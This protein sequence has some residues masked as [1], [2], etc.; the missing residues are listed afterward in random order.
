MTKRAL[1][2]SLY[3]PRATH[4]IAKLRGSQN[5]PSAAHERL[6]QDLEALEKFSGQVPSS[7]RSIRAKCR[8]EM[9]SS[10]D[11]AI[12]RKRNRSPIIKDV[13]EEMVQRHEEYQEVFALESIP[14]SDIS[15]ELA[16]V[17][18]IDELARLYEKVGMSPE[19]MQEKLFDPDKS[20]EYT[21]GIFHLLNDELAEMIDS[22][23]YIFL[24]VS[25]EDENGD[26]R[27][28][29]CLSVRTDNKEYKQ[30]AFNLSEFSERVQ[31]KFKEAVDNNR[32]AAALDIVVDPEFQGR[33]VSLAVEYCM[34]KILAR[35]GFDFAMFEIYKIVGAQNEDG[36]IFE[37][38]LP[39]GPSLRIHSMIGAK[40]VGTVER[41][42]QEVGDWQVAVDSMLYCI[43]L[44]GIDIIRRRVDQFE[45]RRMI[46][47]TIDL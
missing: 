15:V 17:D 41:P 9:S 19:N 24:K 4:M 20:F 47:E 42:T 45:I 35:R 39:N 1:Q 44:K 8:R 5:D 21:G 2:D 26:P 14:E 27:V 13:E 16:T 36:E 30:L 31:A 43:D 18:D 34:S 28:I 6:M 22:G 25:V 10:P 12:R 3:K 33:K 7:R 29:A 37:L 38:N 23:R 46:D 11:S 32:V 40:D